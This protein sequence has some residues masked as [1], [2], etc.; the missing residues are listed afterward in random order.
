[1]EGLVSLTITF[2]HLLLCYVVTKVRDVIKLRESFFLSFLVDCFVQS[3]VISKEKQRR[4]CC[5]DLC[6][7]FFNFL[8]EQFRRKVKVPYYS[9]ASFFINVFSTMTNLVAE[10]K[11]IAIN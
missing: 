11:Y 7:D 9:L 5:P 10:L 2:V 4:L 8:I 1:M 6:T 3:S